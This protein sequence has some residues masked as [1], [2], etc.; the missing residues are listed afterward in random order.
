MCH[1]ELVS[2]KESFGQDLQLDIK[3]QLYPGL[4]LFLFVWTKT[5]PKSHRLMNPCRRLR[6]ARGIISMVLH[7]RQLFLRSHR[8]EIIHLAHQSMPVPSNDSKAGFFVHCLP[9]FNELSNSY[10]DDNESSFLINCP[11]YTWKIF[12]ITGSRAATIFP[13]RGRAP[14]RDK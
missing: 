11:N 5:N 4:F 9:F 3:L 13:S 7:A 6:S 8:C 1:H 2:P 14:G 12:P 10:R